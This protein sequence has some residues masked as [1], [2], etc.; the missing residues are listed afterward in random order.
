MN[1]KIL[2]L[3][4]LGLFFLS[5]QI[6]AQDYISKKTIGNNGNSFF[7]FKDNNQ[8]KNLTAHKA[9]EELLK[10]PSTV[11]L[12][13]SADIKDI[14]SQL[15]TEKYQ[16]YY[17][18]IK[19]EHSNYNVQYK[20]GVI[21][22]MNGEVYD[23][24]ADT[25]PKI[26]ESQAFQN[27][28]SRVAAKKYMWEKG[29]ETEDY[30]KPKGELVILPVQQANLTYKFIL[31]YKFDIFAAEPMSR[32]YIYISAVD[33]KV[34]A[35]D[36]I[37]KHSLEEKS[38]EL[39][40]YNVF[41]DKERDEN[42]RNT[43]KTLELGNA[44]TRYSGTKA[45]E[46]SKI[47]SNFVLF[48][49]T[50]GNGVRTYNS[51]KTQNL[52]NNDFTDADNNWTAAE[53]DNENFDNAA[54][55]AHW[56]VA[57]TY[58]YF[59]E[60]F[61]RNS[62]DDKGTL[63][64]SYVHYGDSYENASWNGSSMVYG[65]GASYFKPL[66]AFDVTAHELGHGVCQATAGLAYQRE[67]GALNEGFSDIWGA[68]VENKY[69]PEKENWLIGEDIAKTTP[70]FLR[71]M[72]NPKAAGQPDTYRGSNW[73]AA[74]VEEGCVTPGRDTN[75]Y[76]GVHTNSGVLNHWYYILVMGKAGTNDIG[77]S[78]NVTG[79]GFDKASK[80]AYRLESNY[81]T[82][83]SDFKTT[84]DYAI[85][86][87]ADLYG[88][89][90]PEVVATQNAFYAVGIGGQFNP[91]VD[92]TA[93]SIPLNLKANNTDNV[94]TFL[95]W[96]NSTDNFAVDKYN[97]YKDNVL[98]G[99]SYKNFFHVKGLSATTTY[100]FKV[101]AV[102]EAGNMS[103]FS[104]V[105]PVTTSD[106]GIA[107]C[108]S[109]SNSTDIVKIERVQINTI[110]NPSVGNKGYE[111][112]SYL[113]TDLEIDKTYELTI[114][115]YFS[116]NQSVLRYRVFIDYNNNGVFTD[117]GE[118]VYSYTAA[119]GTNSAKAS[120]TIPTNAV[121][122]RVRMRV[123]VTTSSLPASCATFANG[124]V[125]DY[126]LNIVDKLAVN[127]VDT[128]KLAIYPNPVKDV[129]TIQSKDNGEYNYKIYDIS[130]KLISKGKTNSKKINTQSLNVGNYLLETSDANGNKNT[131]KFIKH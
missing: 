55:D 111:D 109:T 70:K 22:S 81:L 52:V 47:G 91:N 112:F 74:T 89:N 93:P 97:V 113:S 114:T 92:T 61:N 24:F 94:S 19:V 36:A 40:D 90:S 128:S 98:L 25:T 123:S 51:K 116:T 84:R 75:D 21:S 35:T 130:G 29:Y 101:Q 9:F 119:S 8:T 64:K 20:N 38:K 26:S 37:M 32:D 103:A 131:L 30:S 15:H 87:A 7:I 96:D 53:F 50:R 127:E 33:G 28:I 126:T 86:A 106:T 63:L 59:K 108:T 10:L 56:G 78:Y 31:S 57:K 68:A 45:I 82:S 115:P 117:D 3:G 69:A 76:C 83:S 110:D 104:N 118:T 85:K 102:D 80:I 41:S 42:L 100:N 6:Y 23:V 54:L 62:Y 60:M 95:T 120:I 5:N 18:G 39:I 13:K 48:D 44:D 66:T 1:K 125:E 17:N 73:K 58:D 49:K 105:L 129:L 65:D 16:S 121:K 27:A 77:K 99:M 14:N 107:Y 88:D 4:L 2:T 72:S 34:L 43:L 12:R 122:N 79:I 67:S 124:Q 11:E 71:S 46:T